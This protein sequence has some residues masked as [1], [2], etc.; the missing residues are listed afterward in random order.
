M[1][2]CRSQIIYRIC[3]ILY[4][5]TALE[6][7]FCVAY[8]ISVLSVLCHLTFR[9]QSLGYSNVA[10]SHL[11]LFSKC[12]CLFNCEESV[13]C[14]ALS[15]STTF[16]YMQIDK[17]IIMRMRERAYRSTTLCYSIYI[18]LTFPQTDIDLV[19]IADTSPPGYMM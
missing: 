10:Q 1:R 8:V 13:R 9:I 11:I 3:I 15:L 4:T 6:N 17:T 14:C 12:T 5:H 18:S 19:K 2:S 16:I 7:T